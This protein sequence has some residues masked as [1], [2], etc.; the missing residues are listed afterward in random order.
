VLSDDICALSFDRDGRPDAHAG[1]PKNKLWQDALVEL[2]R[3]PARLDTVR[4]G[5]HKYHLPLDSAAGAVPLGRI[6]VL[7]EASFARHE[8]IARLH[9]TAAFD[10]VF[11]NTYRRHLVAPMGQAQAHFARCAALLRRVPVFALSR[12]WGFGTFA[13]DAAALERHFLDDSATALAG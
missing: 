9:G 6:Y 8:G 11:N 2:G 1:I 5:L 12:S 4:D 7:R 3:D 10:E 13:Q